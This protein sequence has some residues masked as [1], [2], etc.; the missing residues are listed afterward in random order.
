MR[1]MRRAALVCLALLWFT[2]AAQAKHE[3]EGVVERMPYDSFYG[4][5]I[6]SGRPVEVTPQTKLK[7]KRGPLVIGAWVEVEGVFVG[8]HFIATE[9]EVKRPRY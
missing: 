5:W 9:I 3:F 7:S 4:I 2:H 1:T 6:V 8:G